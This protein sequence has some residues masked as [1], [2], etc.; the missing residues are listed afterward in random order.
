MRGTSSARGVLPP[1]SGT[2][3]LGQPGIVCYLTGLSHI[4]PVKADLFPGRFS[5]KR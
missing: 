1:G 3:F 4:D 2:R 5:T